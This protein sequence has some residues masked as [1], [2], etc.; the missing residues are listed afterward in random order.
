MYRLNIDS[1]Q[2]ELSE[3]EIEKLDIISNN[4]SLHLIEGNASVKAELIDIDLDNKVVTLDI[5]G[6]QHT[7]VIED[8]LDRLIDE[9]GF[10]AEANV[11]VKDIKAPMPGLVLEV[12]VKEGD[13]VEKDSQLLIL[14]AMK[15]ENVIKCPSDGIVK[16]ISIKK[17]D[18]VEKGQLLIS[19]D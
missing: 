12:M 11:V 2:F 10:T 3:A 16:E 13:Q 19:L 8:K 18:A 9:L 1:S 14:E 6:K 5:N 15:M 4:N 7:V 17:G